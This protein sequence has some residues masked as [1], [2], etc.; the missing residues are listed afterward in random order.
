MKTTLKSTFAP[1]HF[2]I[3]IIGLM[4][5]F[6]DSVFQIGFPQAKS[7]IR[8]NSSQS[9]G[10]GGAGIGA[11]N[12][13]D[14]NYLNPAVLVHS[15]GRYFYT[16]GGST[17]FAAGI[18]EASKDVIMPASL[19]YFQEFRNRDLKKGESDLGL[20]VQPM[21]VKDVSLALG[22]FISQSM[23]IGITGHQYSVS[24]D[25]EKNQSVTRTLL[26]AG[27][28]WSP[29]Q[30]LGFGLVFY[31]IG[32]IDKSE[33]FPAEVRP[34]TRFAVGTHFLYKDFLRF[35]ADLLSGDHN[36][37]KGPTV[38]LGFEDY[39]KKWLIWRIGFQGNQDTGQQLGTTGLGFEGPRFVLNYA[40]QRE[41]VVG[42]Y[43]KHSIDLTFPF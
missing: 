4:F 31:N 21:T 42:D 7:T 14:I 26:D 1:F 23:A 40:F 15:F 10:A 6:T 2:F 13:A 32:F 17:R 22:D 43:S 9:D 29:L 34:L 19:A 12:A 36:S 28:L 25:D 20:A 5:Y 11:V 38:M 39:M 18:S 24:F 8:N 41:M 27:L 16:T 35:R 3:A 30:N 33:V 37:M